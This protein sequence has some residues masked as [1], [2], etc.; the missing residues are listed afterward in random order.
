[1]LL[2]AY[3]V[4]IWKYCKSIQSSANQ[5]NRVYLGTRVYSESKGMTGLY[6]TLILLV[7]GVHGKP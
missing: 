2:Q 4:V 6:Q 3:Y 1:M 7:K 5:S